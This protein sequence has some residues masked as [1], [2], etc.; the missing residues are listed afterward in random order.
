[1]RHPFDLSI[2]TIS[3]IVLGSDSSRVYQHY[4]KATGSISLSRPITGTKMGEVP[5]NSFSNGWQKRGAKAFEHITTRS[6]YIF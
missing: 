3:A 5:E 1:V 2:A 6:L 4:P